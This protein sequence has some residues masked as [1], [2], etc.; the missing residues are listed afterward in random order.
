VL[1]E[2]V[3]GRPHRRPAEPVDERGRRLDQLGGRDVADVREAE[4]V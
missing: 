2:Q 1:D 4:A 3:V